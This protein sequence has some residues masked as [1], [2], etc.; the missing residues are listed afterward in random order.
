M[1]ATII[2]AGQASMHIAH[3]LSAE[4]HRVTLI[5]SVPERIHQAEP[6]LDVRTMCAHG[7][8][9]QVLEN[10]GVRSADLVAAVM[11]SDE[12]NLIVALTA[13]QLGAKR[14]AARV[15]NRTYFEGARIAY[16]NLLGI[17]LI[18]HRTH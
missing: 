5:D 15:F 2:G 3:A 13:K 16:C 4:D 17:D 14:T 1:D 6:E 10:V 7:A 18:S 11:Q 12:V 9:P 8:S